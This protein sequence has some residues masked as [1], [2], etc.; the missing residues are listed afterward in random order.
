VAPATDRDS[1]TV[2]VTEADHSIAALQN[3]WPVLHDDWKRWA[4]ALADNDAARAHTYRDLKGKEWT[5][6]V[7]QIVLHV[8]NHATHHRGQVSG[9]L[10]SLGLTP[11]PLD[12]SYYCRE[13]RVS[14]QVA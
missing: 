4:G 8:V 5:L 2:F 13:V 10:R 12:L 14:S 6:S 3:Q 1:P 7:W 11:P 9:F